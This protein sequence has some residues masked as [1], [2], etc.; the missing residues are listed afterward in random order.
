MLRYLMRSLFVVI[1]CL[2][3]F[4]AVSSTRSLLPIHAAKG[5]SSSLAVSVGY[6][7][8]KHQSSLNPGAFPV[9]W[10]GSPNTIF[11]G[12]PVYGSSPCGTLPHCY[13]G[14]AIRLDNSG[15]SDITINNVSVDDH[16]SL[17]GGK[18]F[19]LW[20][21]FTVP[22]GKSVILAQN[23]PGNDP[24]SNNFDTSGAPKGNCTPLSVAPTVTITTGGVSTTLV[25]STHVLD[26]NGI[27]T[28]SCQVQQNEAIQWR[29]IGSAGV[30]TATLT[31]SPATTTLPVGQQ[32]TETATLVDGGSVG[33][34][35]ANVTFS[36]PAG[37]DAGQTGTAVTDQTGKA[38]F[39]YTNT[40]AGTDTVVASVPTAYTVGPFQSNQTSV[41]WTNGGPPSWSA[42]DI[43]HPALAGS[44]TLNNGVW[45]IAGSGTDIGGTADQFH[46]VW[47]PLAA[48]GGIRA[49]VLTQ[50]NTNSRARA[51][52]MV[53]QSSD[54]SA[55]FYMVGVT[56]QR[57]IFVLKRATQGGGVSTVTSLAGM[58]PVYLQVQRS[59]NTYTAYTSSDGSTWTLIPGSSVT[60][61]LTGTVLAGMAVTSHTASKVSTA[62]FDTVSTP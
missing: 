55:P 1:I 39:T 29:H 44:D 62:T 15:T 60:L 46:F 10:S 56:P 52:V 14:G 58:V 40:A 20:G 3:L 2:L 13:D 42:A 31:L 12:N 5:L 41:L 23:P 26:T 6:A 57:G 4:L 59:G 36:I 17:P 16:S 53:R 35:N 43:G 22:A 9:P 11:L 30:K 50:T 45:T 47:Q 19:N 28:E 33:L 38:S 37:P 61:N 34:P 25:D 27:D 49:R 48:D 18:V 8:D 7:E 54:A 32:V 51:G 21:S 24:K